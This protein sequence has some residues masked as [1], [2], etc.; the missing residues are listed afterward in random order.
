MTWLYPNPF[1][2]TWRIEAKHIDHYQHVNNVAYVTQLETTSWAHSNQLGLT[3][4]QYQGIDRGMVISQHQINYLAA[5]HY[6][7]VIDCATWITQCD[8]KLKLTRQFQFIR[9]A[10]QK[11][12]LT[13]QTDFI[14]IVLSSGKP[15]R[16]PALFADTYSAAL[17]L[18]S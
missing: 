9:T 18:T 8:K 4:E 14:C 17:T 15:T 5:A 12:L 1:I 13:A 11:T 6:G 3:I 7:D 10:D 2:K 16:M